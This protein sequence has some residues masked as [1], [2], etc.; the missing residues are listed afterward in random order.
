MEQRTKTIL[1]IVAF[2]TLPLTIPLTLISL[3]MAAGLFFIV[4][5]VIMSWP[6][7]I[8]T[9]TA[10]VVILYGVYKWLSRNG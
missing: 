6:I 2:I 5:A 10:I 3:S 9:V 7:E 1:W 8:M 4:L